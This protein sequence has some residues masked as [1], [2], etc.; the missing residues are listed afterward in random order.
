MTTMKSALGLDNDQRLAKMIEIKDNYLSGNLSLEE[1]QALL[2]QYIGTCTPDEFAY[3]EQQL[4][5]SYTDE[6]ITHRMDDLLALFDGILVRAD[7]TYPENHPLW[8]YVT[9]IKAGLAV[10]N[11]AEELLKAPHFIKNPWLGVYDKLSEWSRHLSRKQNQLYPALETYGFDRPTKIMWTFDDK[12]RDLISESRRLLQADKIDQFLALQPKMIDAFRDLADKEQEVLLPTAWKLVNEEEFS[13]MSRG[14]HE[15][16]FALI[17]PPPYYGDMKVAGKDMAT[18]PIDTT[19]TK[20]ANFMQ[21]FA[22]LLSKYN[23][24]PTPSPET[25][26]D[27][28]TGKL[29]L[30]RINL[31]FKHMPVDL[32]YV[33]EN[34]LVKFYSDTK[35]RI[36][37][38]SANVIGREV[39][40][41]HPAKSVHLV[42]EIIEK[43]RSGEQDKAEFWINKPEAFIYI[44][45]T[46]VRDEAGNF[47]GVLEMMQD[48]TRIRSLEGSRTL[49]TWDSETHGDAVDAAT[50]DSVN[51]AL[52]ENTTPEA[53]AHTITIKGITITADTKLFDLF[54]KVEGL[55]QY[56]PT[57]N[58]NFKML[59]TPFGKIMA[60][61]AT[62]GM[63]CER[64]GM[65][66]KDIIDAIA[67]YIKA[68]YKG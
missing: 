28:A 22:A 26:L 5:G 12:V 18:S 15:I 23:M 39:R 58:S 66:Q 31:L 45:Y 44:L 30:E 6:E 64:T 20:T 46:A 17:T 50:T 16:G 11:E 41:C 9:E 51:T 40:N 24:S 43:F 13:Y 32:S 52:D 42:E 37:P 10:M 65:S 2:K 3:G 33:D 27:V 61:K 29:S 35:H 67:N 55:R 14:D 19:D 7:N 56:M 47:K 59:N 34:E 57:I 60:R 1:G 48:C 38:R 49:L 4:K 62:I 36:F 53:T 63:A 25:E 21:D 54:D 68:H 8:V